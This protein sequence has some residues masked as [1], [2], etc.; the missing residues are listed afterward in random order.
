MSVL[1]YKAVKCLQDCGSGLYFGIVAPDVHQV[2]YI[3]QAALQQA[4]VLQVCRG[5]GQLC[6]C[7]TM[8]ALH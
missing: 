6:Y 1:C 3:Q 8:R 5:A 4:Q 7:N 2:M